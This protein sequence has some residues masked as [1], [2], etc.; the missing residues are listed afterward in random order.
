MF[1]GIFEGG[2]GV[3]AVEGGFFF[4]G[5]HGDSVVEFGGSG[6]VFFHGDAEGGE[7]IGGGCFFEEGGVGHGFGAGVVSAGGEFFDSVVPCGFCGGV[8]FLGGLEIGEEGGVLFLADGFFGV[9]GV[10]G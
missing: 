1:A 3:H 10:D 4:I 7:V 8:V 9:D 6:F 5:D 2:F